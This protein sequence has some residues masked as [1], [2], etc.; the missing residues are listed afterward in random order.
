M[1]HEI[2]INRDERDGSDGDVI[3]YEITI[4]DSIVRFHCAGEGK[5]RL[6]TNIAEFISLLLFENEKLLINIRTNPNRNR[7]FEQI[8]KKF[9]QWLATQREYETQNR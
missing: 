3:I 2:K 7:Y 5:A 8:R 6:K 4:D 9:F 1:K